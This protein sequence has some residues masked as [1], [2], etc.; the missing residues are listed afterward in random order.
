MRK[1][2]KESAGEG[3]GTCCPPRRQMKKLPALRKT[4]A[5]L[6]AGAWSPADTILLVMLTGLSSLPRFPQPRAKAAAVGGRLEESCGRSRDFGQEG[7][8]RRSYICGGLSHE[9]QRVP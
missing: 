6:P 5:Q 1:S 2:S 4:P 3:T 7:L 9:P 8:P